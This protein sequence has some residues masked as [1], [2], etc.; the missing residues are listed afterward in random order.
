MPAIYDDIL[1]NK[2][3]T[4]KVSGSTSEIESLLYYVNEIV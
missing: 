4:G 1:A 3:H 2:S